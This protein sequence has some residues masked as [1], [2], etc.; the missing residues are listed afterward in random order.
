M[1]KQNSLR[2]VRLQQASYTTNL[3]ELRVQTPLGSTKTKEQVLPALLFWWI[4]KKGES[5]GSGVNDCR[6]Q[7][8]PTLTEGAELFAR[9]KSEPRDRERL[10]SGQPEKARI[11]PPTNV[12]FFN[13]SVLADGI[14]P[15]NVR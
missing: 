8:E 14:N 6:W 7:S 12:C 11:C 4:S 5:N 15:T 9:A 1:R 13:K 3:G 2:A 10:P